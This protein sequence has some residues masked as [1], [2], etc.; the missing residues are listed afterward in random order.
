MR[1][2]NNKG[3]KREDILQRRHTLGVKRE[4]IRNALTFGKGKHKKESIKIVVVIIVVV[5]VVRK[6]GAP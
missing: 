1:P 4:S 2:E 5:V 3:D 6:A